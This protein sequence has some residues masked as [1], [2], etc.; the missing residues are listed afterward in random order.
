MILLFL[1]LILCEAVMGDKRTKQIVSLVDIPV[2]KLL[3]LRIFPRLTKEQCGFALRY[4][5]LFFCPAF[6]NLPLSPAISG[7]EVGK[8]IAVFGTDHPR[9]RLVDLLR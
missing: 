9:H 1:I 3:D 4:I 2:R 5:N 6:V 7:I 8:I